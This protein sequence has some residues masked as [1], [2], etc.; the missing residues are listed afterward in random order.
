MIVA[1]EGEGTTAGL[2]EVNGDLGARVEEVAPE[3]GARLVDLPRGVGVAEAVEEYRD[4][5]GVAYAEPNYLYRPVQSPT[6]P[7]DPD[8]RALWGLHNTGQTGG[9]ADADVDAPEAWEKLGE[10]SPVV[11]A[12]IDSGVDV[13]HP[14]LAANVWRNPGETPNN[15]RDDDGNGYVDDVNGWDF[16]NGDASVYDGTQDDHG[17][18]VAGTIAAAHDNGTG[19]AGLGR[20]VK[21][22]PLKFIDGE[23]GSAFDAARAIDYAVAQ[24]VP[25]SNNS[26]GGPKESRYVKEAIDRARAKG[27]LLVAA[28]GNSGLDNDSSTERSY[29]ASSASENIVS[30]AATNSRDELAWFSNY[31]ATGVDLGAPGV[32]I[33]STTAGGGYGGKSGTS[34][35]TPHVAGAA[36]LLLGKDPNLGYSEVKSLLLSGVDPSPSLA[37]KTVTGGRLNAANSLAALPE[38]AQTSAP[39]PPPPDTTAPSVTN[40]RPAPASSIKNRR[41]EVSAVVKDSGKPVGKARISL[42]FDGRKV[43]FVY[44][45]TRGRLSFKP[46]GELAF[47]RHTVRVVAQDASGNRTDR[48]W[49]FRIVR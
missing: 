39:E 48:R 9:T 12:V 1:L 24:G 17:T 16:A 25:V 4:A 8:F 28:A 33:L 45:A 14:D 21:V 47:G 2:R 31:G 32:G 36:A 43:G 3:S 41:P 27:H 26:W 37:G 19:V 13:S 20:N 35:A 11:V 44:D 7:S 29:P 46:R 18:H 22:M 6:T 30:V 15:G 42:Y 34:M 23:F 38:T 40:L 49:G 5:P 10:S